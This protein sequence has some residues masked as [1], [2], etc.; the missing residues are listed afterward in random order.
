MKKIALD[1][2]GVVFDTENLYRVYTEMYDVDHF[3]GDNV[4]VNTQRLFTKRYSWNEND[5]E[6][7]YDK[8][9][10][11]ILEKGPVMTGC[12]DVLKKLIN[13]F[14]IVVITSRRDTE[15]DYAKKFF[16]SLNISVDIYN[17]C[18]KIKK[19]LDLNIDYIVDDDPITCVEASNSKIKALY[20]KNNA[21]DFLEENENLK[22][23]CNWGEIY[24]YFMLGGK[25][26]NQN[27]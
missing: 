22:N 19:C 8:Y 26:E 14:E 25:S 4:I 18:S 23:V 15:L 3:H 6:L 2:D 27:K 20:F 21:S 10:P 7:F 24:K 11:Y 12:I 9:A 13:Y 5:F 17:N 1:L 16:E